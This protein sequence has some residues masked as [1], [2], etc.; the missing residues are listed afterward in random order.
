M[1]SRADDRAAQNNL[2]QYL[3]GATSIKTAVEGDR[4]LGGKADTC[5][6]TEL[7]EYG[8]IPVGDTLYLGAHFAVEVIA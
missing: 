5:R 2:D 4:T 3:V 6:V 8:V 7:R 1:V